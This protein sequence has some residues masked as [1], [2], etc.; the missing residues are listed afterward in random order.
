MRATG[1]VLPSANQFTMSSH[2]EAISQTLYY[3]YNDK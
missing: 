3:N 2:P 1:L